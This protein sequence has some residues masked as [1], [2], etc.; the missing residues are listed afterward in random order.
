MMETMTATCA[1]C[2][3]HTQT[4]TGTVGYADTLRFMEATL[5]AL[6]TETED[7]FTVIPSEVLQCPE[8]TRRMLGAGIGMCAGQMKTVGAFLARDEQ[9][10]STREWTDDEKSFA[11]DHH[12]VQTL[13]GMVRNARDLENGLESGDFG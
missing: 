12:A 5:A 11:I 10:T 3:A 2:E 7:A 1:A 9:Q 13:E 6:K 8:C 4:E